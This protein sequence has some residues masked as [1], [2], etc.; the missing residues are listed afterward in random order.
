MKGWNAHSPVTGSQLRLHQVAVKLAV[1]FNFS[2]GT[3]IA[4]SGESLTDPE[5]L[6]SFAMEYSHFFSRRPSNAKR[7]ETTHSTILPHQ[8]ERDA[9]QRSKQREMQI[10]R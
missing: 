7:S 3:S 8:L 1:V 10:K 2:Q 6:I 4:V 5:H 9:V